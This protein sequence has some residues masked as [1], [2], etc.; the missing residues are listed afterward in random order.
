MVGGYLRYFSG[1]TYNELIRVDDVDQR[2]E[3]YGH[4]AGSFRL[5]DG[6]SLDLRVEKD[7]NLGGGRLLGVGI[8]VFNAGNA[9]TAIEAEQSLDSD[10]PFGAPRRLIRGRVWRLGARLQF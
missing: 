6:L 2:S 8:D 7:F 4:P 3:I 9:D 1:N 10:R 5:D